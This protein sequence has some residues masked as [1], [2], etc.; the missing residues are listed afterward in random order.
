MSW[1]LFNITRIYVNQTILFD[2]YYY[3]QIY[4]FYAKNLLLPMDEKSSSNLL[5]P[6]DEK[7]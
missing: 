3:I 6:M 4:Y 7:S 1:Y 5:L 2:T